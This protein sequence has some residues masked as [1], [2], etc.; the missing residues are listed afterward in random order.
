MCK[1]PKLIKPLM[2]GAATSMRVCED[3]G[4]EIALIPVPII[5]SV[6]CEK[7]SERRLIIVLTPTTNTSC[8]LSPR[9]KHATNNHEARRDGTFTYSEDKTSGEET[10]KVLASGMAA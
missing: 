8:V 7:W 6:G 3:H 9:V 1:V 4:K 2:I 10:G 5:K